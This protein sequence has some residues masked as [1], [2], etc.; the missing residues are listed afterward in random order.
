[1]M[2]RLLVFLSCLMISLIVAFLSIDYP[3]EY[4][5]VLGI[6]TLTGGLLALFEFLTKSK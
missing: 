3:F 6:I 5:L 4:N 2:D 1:M